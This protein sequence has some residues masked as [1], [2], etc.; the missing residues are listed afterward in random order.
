VEERGERTWVCWSPLS[1]YTPE[2]KQSLIDRLDPYVKQL[3]THGLLQ[4]A[5]IYTFDERGEDFFPVIK[6]Y[7]GMVKERY[8]EIKTLTTAH[9]AQ[10]PKVMADLN[11]DWNCPLTAVYD[12]DRAEAC[13]KAGQEVWAYICLGPRYPYANWLADFPLI[14]S[15]VIW[16]QAF[17]QKM[18]GFLY[19]GVN[20][21]GREHND[22]PLDPSR[23]PFLDWSITSGGQYSWL[24]GDGVLL[25]PGREGPIGSIRLANIRDGL[26]DVEYLWLLGKCKGDLESAREA[27]RPVTESLTTFTRDP[28]VLLSQREWVAR[29]M[30]R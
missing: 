5:Y 26:E 1:V 10:D 13:R 17:H 30:T 4:D 2:F 19:W 28:G 29:E 22:A 6:E 7:F 27:C 24:H 11:V 16:W 9:I 8:P 15:R 12:F 25:Y 18:D 3:R 14:E 20:I 23:F 21:W